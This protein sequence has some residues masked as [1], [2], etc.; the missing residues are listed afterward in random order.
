M[1]PEASPTPESPLETCS[2]VI[3]GLGLRRFVIVRRDE[4]SQMQHVSPPRTRIRD[5]QPGDEV[6]YKGRRHIVR[7]LEIYE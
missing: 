5:L 1:T 3:I 4:P 6:L 2:A 7:R